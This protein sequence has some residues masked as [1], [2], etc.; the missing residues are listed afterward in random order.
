MLEALLTK[1]QTN[2]SC[3]SSTESQDQQPALRPARGRNNQLSISSSQ[4]LQDTASGRTA[5]LGK[6]SAITSNK[7]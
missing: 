1:H 2:P 5:L 4:H 6:Q 7:P 3:L